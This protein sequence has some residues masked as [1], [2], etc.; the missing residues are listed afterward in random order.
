MYPLAD[1]LMVDRDADEQALRS[2]VDAIRHAWDVGDGA[3]FGAPFAADAD[4]TVWNGHYMKGRDAIAQGHQH[5]FDTF[6]RN[7]K[8]HLRVTGIRFL[9]DDV[10][11]VRGHGHL[12][13]AAGNQ[14]GDGV[15]PLFVMTK[16]NGAWQIAAFQNT[17]LMPL[18][19]GAAADTE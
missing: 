6:Y 17:P 16:E 19:S 11:L 7:T 8:N 5:I 4:Y 1:P 9:R 3:A 10:A 13:D 15:T 2:L 18:P 12:S 14:L